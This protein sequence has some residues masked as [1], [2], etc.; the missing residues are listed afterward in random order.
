MDIGG[1]VFLSGENALVILNK[2]RVFQQNAFFLNETTARKFQILRFDVH[3]N[4]IAICFHRRKHRRA[5]PQ[6]RIE[7]GVPYE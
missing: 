2:E 1:I 7:Y 3:P 6:K 5:T 4:A